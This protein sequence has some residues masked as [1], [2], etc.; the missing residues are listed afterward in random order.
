MSHRPV[1]RN[2]QKY[3]YKTDEFVHISTKYRIKLSKRRIS[4]THHASFIY[5]P[6][7]DFIST[8]LSTPFHSG[9]ITPTHLRSGGDNVVARHA[10]DLLLDDETG[11]AAGLRARLGVQRGHAAVDAWER[12]SSQEV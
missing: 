1:V 9:V 7:T 2:N 12:E 11:H 3:D 4:K 8:S 5:L 10:A 6:F